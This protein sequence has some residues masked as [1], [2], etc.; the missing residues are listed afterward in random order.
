MAKTANDY[1]FGETK[2]DDATKSIASRTDQPA[3]G[4]NA[5]FVGNPKFGAGGHWASYEEIGEWPD[6]G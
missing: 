6:F 5:W 2:R 3:D 4:W 1:T